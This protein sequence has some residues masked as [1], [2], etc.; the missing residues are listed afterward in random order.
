MPALDGDGNSYPGNF[1]P[2]S[3]SIS[4]PKPAGVHLHQGCT[5]AGPHS[6]LPTCLDATFGPSSSPTP[7]VSFSFESDAIRAFGGILH[8]LADEYGPPHWGVPEYFLARGITWSATPHRI[9]SRRPEGLFPTWSWSGWRGD[10]TTD[11]TK[12]R[13]HFGNV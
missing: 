11:S 12:S 8:S 7:S 4:F 3:S 10:C 6:I 1:G 13:I 9:A 2:I 5:P